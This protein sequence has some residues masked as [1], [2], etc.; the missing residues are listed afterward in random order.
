MNKW[1]AVDAYQ[2]EQLERSIVQRLPFLKFAPVL[3]ISAVKRQGFGPVWKAIADAR[4]GPARSA[5]SCGTRTR[6]A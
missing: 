4:S 6:A 2:K 5:P 3:Q 1:D